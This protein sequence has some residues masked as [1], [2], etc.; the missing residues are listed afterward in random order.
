MILATVLFML[1]LLC[2]FAGSVAQRRQGSY[3]VEAEKSEAGIHEEAWD[4][5]VDINSADLKELASL[6]GIGEVLAQR[7]IDYREENGPFVSAGEI[8]KVE[9]ISAQK[10]AA[11]RDDITVKEA[12]E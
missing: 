1:L 9:G 8:M 10:F 11:I 7:I 5:P 12:A 4:R 6:D 3:A 2:I